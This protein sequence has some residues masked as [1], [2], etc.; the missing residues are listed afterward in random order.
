MTTMQS[1]SRTAGPAGGGRSAV[2]ARFE[3]RADG[4][5][6]PRCKVVVSG[7]GAAGG[8]EIDVTGN[9]TVAIAHALWQVRGGDPVGNWCEAERV[10]EQLSGMGASTEGSRLA[11]GSPI[12]APAVD[13]GT[14][15]RQPQIVVGGKRKLNRR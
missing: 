2:A 4:Q 14:A 5:T 1:G 7:V 15:Q 6:G 12:A 8:R 13:D 9:L 3:K 10:L 11:P